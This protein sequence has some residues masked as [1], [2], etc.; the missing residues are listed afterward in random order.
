MVML[1]IKN[2]GPVTLF[3]MGRSPLGFLLYPV[4]A[5]LAGD[6]LIDTGTNRADKQFL[7]ALTGRSIGK[8]VN[9]HHHEDHIGNNGD[10]QERFKIP[11]YAHPYALPCLE[12]PRLN[13]LRP[14]QRIVWDWPKSSKGADV[15]ASI[16]AGNLHFEVINS[17]GHT[18]DHICLYEPDRKWLFSGD[19]FC[20]TT[21]IYLRSDENYLQI[22]ETLKDL[23]RLKIETIFC[24]LKGA[25][26]NGKE[27]L[28]RKIKKMEQLRDRVLKLQEKRLS[29]QDIRQ[30][31][32]GK[33]GAWN[34]I[35][36]GHYSKQNTIDSILSGK[37]PDQS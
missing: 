32:L 15:G 35:T 30:A 8:I 6:T 28:Q 1:K 23:S 16:D 18:D 27:A 25:V 37:R 5:F 10:I 12:N 34:L 20:G 9:T 14:Y 2:H 13:S 17:P 36:G 11:I 3:Y 33:E 4:Y 19:L 7:S 26:E 21:F 29:T 22:L 24:C 31:V